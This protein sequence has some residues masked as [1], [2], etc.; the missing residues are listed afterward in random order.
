MEQTNT[1]VSLALSML[2][3]YLIFG[4]LILMAIYAVFDRLAE[5]QA[6]KPDVGSGHYSIKDPS[7]WTEDDIR[8]YLKD[9]G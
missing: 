7:S 5:K 4:P 6:K 1:S 9:S 3:I 8:R 2:V